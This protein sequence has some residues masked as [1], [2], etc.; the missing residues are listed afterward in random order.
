MGEIVLAV[1]AHPDDEALG[2]GGTLARHSAEGDQVCLLFLSDGVTSR[3]HGHDPN[4][5]KDEIAARKRMAAVA[6]AALGAQPPRFLDLP[7]NRLDG[8]ELLDV[9]KQ[10]EAVL[11]DLH[12]TIIYTH[13]INDLNVDHRIAHQAVLT[14]CRPL[15]GHSVQAIYAFETASSTEWEPAGLGVGFRPT[16]YV[17][18]SAFRAA[19][20]AAIRAYAAEMRPFPHPRSLEAIEAQ[21]RWRGAQ[22]GMAAAEGLVVVRQRI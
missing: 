2:V 22:A 16:R 4:T 21:W 6:A 9:V 10:I 1:C 7:D 5:S 3:A 13:H 17:D 8:V 19:K 11:A 12:P 20:Q 18:I 15:P 14:A